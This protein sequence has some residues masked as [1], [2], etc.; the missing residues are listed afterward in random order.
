MVVLWKMIMMTDTNQPKRPPPFSIRLDPE[1]R[2]ELEKA[3]AEENRS[4]ANMIETLAK[5]ELE[6][7]KR[8]KK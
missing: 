6:R 4:L 5:R 7:R 3:A 2:K 8:S 1:F